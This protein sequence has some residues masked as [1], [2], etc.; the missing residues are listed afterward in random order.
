MY[1]LGK[2]GR[3]S[4]KGDSAQGGALSK[5]DTRTGKLNEAKMHVRAGVGDTKQHTLQ[6][7]NNIPD[8][9]TIL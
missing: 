4:R 5:A 6:R 7:A 2:E 1:R 3:V 9:Y 8:L